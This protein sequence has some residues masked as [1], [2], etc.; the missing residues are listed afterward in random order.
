MVRVGAIVAL[1]AALVVALAAWLRPTAPALLVR[2]ACDFAV[3]V[4]GVLRCDDEAPRDVAALCG[5]GSSSAALMHGDAVTRDSLC[6][7]TSPRP[8]TDGWSRMRG[9]D[10]AALAIPV[11]LNHASASELES[12]PGI[13][14]EL[15]RRIIEGRPY[16]TVDDLQRVRGIGPARL[17]AVRPRAQVETRGQGL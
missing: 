13:G 16:A 7:A 2:T 5:A 8:G 17:T 1:V 4:D 14:P 15:A 3:E 12:L 6:A 9:E 11:D 10:L